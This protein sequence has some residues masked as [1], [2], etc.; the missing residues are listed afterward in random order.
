M[1]TTIY[2]DSRAAVSGTSSDFQILLR[3]TVHITAGARLRVDK[4][5][6]VDSFFTTDMGRY[7]YYKDGAGSIV[8]Y[9]LPEQA[10]S[11]TRLAAQI[12]LVTGRETKYAEGTNSIQQVI[13]PGQEWLSDEALKA[14]VA[15]FPPGASGVSPS[16]INSILGPGGEDLSGNL[17]WNFVKMNPY[18]DLY[19]RSRK[20][21]CKNVHGT[22]GDHDVLCKVTLDQGISKV[23]SEESPPDVYNDIA[24]AS[25]KTMDFKLTDYLGRVVN[26]RGRS[27]SFQLTIDQ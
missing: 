24:E 23:Q 12:Q 27:L 17:N 19:L 11:S 26:L 10:Y 6:F 13:F 7:I 9:I 21:A 4:L 2:V 14:Y 16:S 5:R 25:F 22:M 8:S 18:D 3:E 20:L 15:G 1:T